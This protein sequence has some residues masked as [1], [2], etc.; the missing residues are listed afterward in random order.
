[1]DYKYIIEDISALVGLIPLALSIVWFKKLNYGFKVLT[2]YLAFSSSTELLVRIFNFSD[3]NI[4][5]IY[6]IFTLTEFLL[7]II[8]LSLSIN[9]LSK[10]H[11]KIIS[12]LLFAIVGILLMFS[13]ISKIIS[14][15][16]IS[17]IFNVIIII[18]S[19]HLFYK[20][21]IDER[22]TNLI[23]VPEFWINIGIFTYFAGTAFL[24]LVISSIIKLENNI[25]YLIWIVNNIFA[26]FGNL[27]FVLGL[28]KIKRY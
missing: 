6:D 24:F 17:L 13:P 4:E 14:N 10:V 23:D 20:L 19:M 28:W 16:Y 7:V 22:Y 25:G 3:Q 11:T 2:L 15:N 12:Y 26:I 8:F 27:F 9:F 21:F 18:Y 1:M 5:I